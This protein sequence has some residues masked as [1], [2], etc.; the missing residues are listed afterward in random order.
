MEGTHEAKFPS[1][2][3]QPEPLI[4]APARRG[5]TGLLYCPL[6]GKIHPLSLSLEVQDFSGTIPK[7]KKITGHRQLLR[8]ALTFTSSS[9]HEVARRAIRD[10]AVPQ[11]QAPGILA[12]QAA[13]PGIVEVSRTVVAQRV[14][15]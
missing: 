8:P 10:T 4:K 15:V 14:A 5:L 11:Q 1:K 9:L 7:R 12:L 13:A 3:A 6:T 2:V